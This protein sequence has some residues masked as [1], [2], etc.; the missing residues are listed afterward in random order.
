MESDGLTTRRNDRVVVTTDNWDT[1]SPA[2]KLECL[3]FR[4]AGREVDTG[5]LTDIEVP[6]AEGE[7]FPP[8]A[9]DNPDAA[10]LTNMQEML[11][12]SMLKQHYSLVERLNSDRPK[13]A[14]HLIQAC[15]PELLSRVKAHPDFEAARRAYNH[16]RIYEIMEICATGAGAHTAYLDLAKLFKLRQTEDFASYVG[17]FRQLKDSFTTKVA[18]KT[19]DQLL[20]MIFNAKFVI[21]L[22]QTEFASQLKD[23]YA[24]ADWTDHATLIEQ[25]TRYTTTGERV[26]ELLK[27]EGPVHANWT[28]QSQQEFLWTC[29]NC[30]KKHRKGECRERK[31]KCGTCGQLG[32]K[33]EFHDRLT[34]AQ[35]RRN[36]SAPIPMKT[37]KTRPDEKKRSIGPRRG[38]S[39]KSRGDS[40]PKERT[41]AFNTDIDDEE[42]S[43]SAELD[44]FH[45]EIQNAWD[46]Y[47]DVNAYMIKIVPKRDP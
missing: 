18:T 42:H 39:S 37:G 44:G 29:Y 11:Y 28:R 31:A 8:I 43:E 38:Q 10:L 40:N 15:S 33:T 35:A 45:E 26:T 14:S 36:E 5:R 6:R 34:E 19:K 12:Q 20:A 47:D 32:H 3:Q 46:E 24:L 21:G 13:V 25:L 30:G 23:V 4:E 2:L 16:L 7:R 41:A 22:N 27:E 9:R 17:K 1:A